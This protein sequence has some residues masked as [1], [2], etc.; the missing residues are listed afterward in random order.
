MALSRFL[1]RLAVKSLPFYKDLSKA[2][3]FVWDDE[4][5]QAFSKLKEHLA[6]PP[7]LTKPQQTEQLYLYLAVAEEAVSLVLVQEEDKR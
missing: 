3:N 6:S 4:C 5:Q 7:V 1:S 2:K